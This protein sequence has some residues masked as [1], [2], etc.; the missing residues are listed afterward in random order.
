MK[1]LKETN[2]QTGHDDSDSDD[3][4]VL[5]QNPTK[6]KIVSKNFLNAPPDRPTIHLPTEMFND[7]K[8][9]FCPCSTQTEPWRGEMNVS[10][11][12]DHVCKSTNMTQNQLMK[13]LKTGRHRVQLVRRVAQEPLVR[14]SNP[15]GARVQWVEGC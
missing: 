14:G 5:A 12:H 10:I 6:A 11:H 13:Q 8:L 15:S 4:Y 3:N 7:P 1:T 2:S 9:C